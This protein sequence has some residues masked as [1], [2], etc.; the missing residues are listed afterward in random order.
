MWW[1]FDPS[2]QETE[3]RGYLCIQEQ[4]DSYIQFLEVQGYTEK[5]S[6]KKKVNKNKQKIVN[7]T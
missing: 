6:I 5:P 3:A 2:T 1:L 4:L 7:T